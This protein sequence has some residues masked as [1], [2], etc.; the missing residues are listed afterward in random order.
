MNIFVFSKVS[1]SKYREKTAIKV[2]SILLPIPRHESIFDT[3]IDTAKV[4]SIVSMSISIF[5][6]NNPVL[7]LQQTLNMVNEQFPSLR[8]SLGIIYQSTSGHL[9][10]SLL[11][12]KLWDSGVHCIFTLAYSLTVAL[13]ADSAC[14]TGLGAGYF[15]TL[16]LYTFCFFATFCFLTLYSV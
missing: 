10:L 8:S 11:S 7:C 9:R 12:K 13:A 15:I 3:D 1:I 5:D 16:L 2:S 6:I 4:S 14:V